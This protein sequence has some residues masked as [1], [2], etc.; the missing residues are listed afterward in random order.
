MYVEGSRDH[1]PS[2]ADLHGYGLRVLGS[3]LFHSEA[4]EFQGIDFLMM[5]S[6]QLQLVILCC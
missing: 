5:V 4:E 6:K 3:T 2:L 1:L